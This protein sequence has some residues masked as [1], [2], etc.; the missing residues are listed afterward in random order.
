MNPIA[1]QPLR[2]THTD[3]DKVE[4][5]RRQG[6]RAPKDGGERPWV[7][8]GHKADPWL[9]PR[10]REVYGALLPWEWRT[11]DQICVRIGGKPA[12]FNRTLR[13]LTEKTLIEGRENYLGKR[14]FKIWLPK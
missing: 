4:C 10:E 11:I 7:P 14:A 6:G 13:S 9:S 1:R 3:T 2:W 12:N 8:T 5:L